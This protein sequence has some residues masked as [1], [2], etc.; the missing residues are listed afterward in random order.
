MYIA[1]FSLSDSL[2]VS[3]LW[4]IVTEAYSRHLVPQDGLI[5][6]RPWQKKPQQISE[7]W[8][9]RGCWLHVDQNAS[10]KHEASNSPD[11]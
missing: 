8:K 2:N 1:Q 11:C 5:L 6:W 3:N 7:S 10:F 4:G 9:T